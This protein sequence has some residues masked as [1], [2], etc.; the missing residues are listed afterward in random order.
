MA[1]PA[2]FLWIGQTLSRMEQLCLRSFIAHGE[3][4][5]LYTYGSIDDLPPGVILRDASEIIPESR[6]FTYGKGFAEGSFAGFSN[7]FRYHLLSQRGGWWFDMDFAL[8]R[9]L[10]KP[11]GL[12]ITSSNVDSWGI[13]ANSCAIHAPAGHPAAL[14][15][16]D[17]TERLLEEGPLEFGATGPGLVQRLVREHN[18][19]SHLAP[20]WLFSP[21]P[22]NQVTR[23]A[24]P[25]T[26]ALVKDQ[27]RLARFLVWQ[28]T[29][30]NFRAG[31][32]R[33]RTCAIHFY[34]EIWRDQGIDKNAVYHPLCLY[35]RLMRRHGV[36]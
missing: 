28:F 17:E 22:C 31:F 25:T 33:P 34:N 18:L 14:W 9:P 13:C 35:E 29:R 11:D 15:L 16:R 21:Y 5:H 1:A 32:V 27:L 30:K 8:L 12:L 6:I 19:D 24:Q 26:A 2:Q 23:V 3:T 7:L 10:P 4:V 20:W 36:S